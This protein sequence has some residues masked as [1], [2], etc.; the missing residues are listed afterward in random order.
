MKHSNIGIHG[1]FKIIAYRWQINVRRLVCWYETHLKAFVIWFH[2]I[3]I[4]T[5][6]YRIQNVEERILST[7]YV[8]NIRQ[9]TMA[10]NLQV[11]SIQSLKSGTNNPK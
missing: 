6:P 3:A 7:G 9:P 8:I 1:N 11:K 5:E 2:N 10:C 4:Y